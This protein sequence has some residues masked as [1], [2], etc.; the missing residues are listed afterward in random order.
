MQELAA[1]DTQYVGNT[2]SLMMKEL[3]RCAT[4]GMAVPEALERASY[5]SNRGYSLYLMNSEAMRR[6]ASFGRMK[7]LGRYIKSRLGSHKILGEYISN[8]TAMAGKHE[9]S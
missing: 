5:V 1:L 3:L 6:T 9:K 4:A 7:D 2:Q 8:F